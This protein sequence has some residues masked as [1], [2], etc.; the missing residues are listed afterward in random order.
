MRT[1]SL[2]FTRI[3]FIAPGSTRLFFRNYRV[4][5]FLYTVY[6]TFCCGTVACAFLV[7][8]KNRMFFDYFSYTPMRRFITYNVYT[9]PENCTFA[10]FTPNTFFWIWDTLNFIILTHVRAK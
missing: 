1:R 2:C 7:I 6:F 9:A 8:S 5:T 3:Y 4:F 10:L